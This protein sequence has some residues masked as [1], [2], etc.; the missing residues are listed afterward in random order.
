MGC[1]GCSSEGGRPF[2]FL[3]KSG[4]DSI[5]LGCGGWLLGRVEG[6]EGRE[7]GKVDH[8]FRFT[9]PWMFISDNPK[10]KRAFVVLF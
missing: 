5:Q 6:E 7:P 4:A 1:L 2:P 10:Q 3:V 9:I 8:G